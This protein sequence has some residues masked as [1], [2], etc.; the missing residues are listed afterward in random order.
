MEPVGKMSSAKAARAE[1]TRR[2]IL[3]A[4]IHEFSAHGMAGARTEAIAQTAKVNKALLFYYF[5]SKQGL[6]AA[7][8]EQVAK[9][10]TLRAMAELDAET[11][12]GERL[13]RTALGHFDRILTEPELRN[14]MEQEMVRFRRGESE[15]MK[16]M[17]ERAYRPMIH[18]LREVIAEGVHRGELCA[19]D[20]LQV[21]CA[22]LGA[23][24]FYFLSAPMTRLAVP[25][26][27]FE[28]AAL[29]RRRKAAIQFLGQALFVD[30]K[31]GAAVAKRVLA[32][33]PMPH[34]TRFSTGRTKR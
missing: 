16:L 32:S 17:A 15:L 19:A 12:A 14:L 26:E 24:V 11:T 33:L 2:R 21:L 9:H 8:F 7:A 23:N 25:F 10:L 30:R 13:L 22:S 29:K 1:A 6:Y 20:W 27:P 3:E 31:H 4:A 34:S 28:Q 18:R 5:K